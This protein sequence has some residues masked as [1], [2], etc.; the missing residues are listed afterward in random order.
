MSNL[1]EEGN[2]KHS[3]GLLVEMSNWQ[4]VLVGT[5][6]QLVFRYFFH[7]ELQI[8]IIFAVEGKQTMYAGVHC[9]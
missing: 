2:S 5:H 1:E 3:C 7:S 9:F 4:K 8:I 6:E